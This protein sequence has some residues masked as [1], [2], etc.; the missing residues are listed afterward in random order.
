MIK[1]F[2][3]HG[4]FNLPWWGYVLYTFIVTQ[5]TI[6]SVTIYLHR[7]QA[8]RA[9]ELHPIV[10]HFFRFWLWMTTGM[11]TKEWAAIHR[12]HHAFSDKVGDPHS[13][14]VLGIKKVFWEGAE[15]YQAE[16]KNK[17]TMEKYGRGTPD[18]WLEKNIYTK[19]NKLGVVI[20]LVIN[21]I[22]FGPIG[23]TIWAIQMIWIP[24]HAAGVVNGI[25]HW[26]GYRNFENQDAARN[27][28]PIGFW[29]G[30]EELHN[31][32]HTFATSAKF[33]YKWYEFDI[34]WVWICIL[35]KLGLAQV[36]KVNPVPHVK[37]I[38]N[39]TPDFATLEAIIVNRYNLMAQ[40]AKALKQDYKNEIVRLQN[41][42]KENISWNKVK[43]MLTKDQDQ[44][45]V[46]EQ[47]TIQKLIANSALFKKIF[48]LRAEI[49]SLWIRSNLSRE[50]LLAKL[51]DWCKKAEE[52]GI[53][54]LR[55]FSMRLKATY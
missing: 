51:Q 34:G 49:S 12:K 53:N 33:S 2:L 27:I 9:L 46:D 42:I 13:P 5:I 11:V 30:G 41:N 52:S 45:T 39:S 40:Y 3:S 7:H 16:A 22:M 37:Q 20:T 35:S 25:G 19:H 38:P 26:F 28:F 36:K 31:N 1:E 15:L 24:F 23:L 4:L 29:I 43:I 54:H 8:H 47:K 6:L 17:E 44:L 18:D 21:L 50:E 48:T 55:T 32:H 14:Q 10:S